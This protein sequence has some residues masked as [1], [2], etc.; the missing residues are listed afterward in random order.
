MRFCELL[1]RTERTLGADRHRR[2]AANLRYAPARGLRRRARRSAGRSLARHRQH[3]AMVGRTRPQPPGRV[4]VPLRAPDEPDSGGHVCGSEGFDARVLAGGYAAWI[5]AKLPLV[6]KSA[7][8]RFAP[9]RPSLWVTRRRPKIDRVACPVADPPL[10]RPAGAHSLCRPG[11]G[12]RGR[13]GKRRHPVRHR[14]RRNFP[15]GRALLVRH[16]AEAVRARGRAV[17]GAACAD[18]PRR[19]HGA[20]RSGAGGRGP[21]RGLARTVG[22]G[23]RRR[24]WDDRRR[25]S[26][27]T[28]GCSPIFA[29]PRRN[30]TT[31]R[32]RRRDEA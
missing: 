1:H 5:E 2:R 13:Q 21:A 30:V 23:R 29:L 6:T 10:H 32:P 15:R 4:R 7:L 16:H 14:R 25:R 26:R 22:A 31:G 17:A 8:D 27:S 11:S 28:T 19:R 18:R 3:R 24:S 20:A 12:S 9:Q